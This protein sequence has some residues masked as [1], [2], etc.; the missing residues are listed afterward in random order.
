MGFDPS[1]YAGAKATSKSLTR[2]EAPRVRYV[3]LT[4]NPPSS[5][6]LMTKYGIFV[7]SALVA[8]FCSTVN[9]LASNMEGLDLRGVGELEG[10]TRSE[11][12]GTNCARS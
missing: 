12:S 11:T 8:K 6:L 10:V 5:V 2:V 7:P 3:R 1:N 4:L 9:P